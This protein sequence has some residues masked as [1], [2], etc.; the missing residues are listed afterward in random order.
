M[1]A[2]PDDIFLPVADAM[3]LHARR[4]RGGNATPA[5]C[6]PGLTRNAADFNGI[7][8]AIA[9]TGRDVYALSLRGRGRS[10]R[11]ADEITYHPLVYRDDVIAALNALNLNEVIFV[12]TSLGGIVTMLVNEIAPERVR[13]AVLN[14][15]GPTLAE[16]GLQRIA[17]YVGGDAGPAA[18]LD[19][20]ADRI[21]A[22]NAVAFPEADDEFWRA[23]A[24]RTF[25]HGSDGWS[26]DYDPGIARAFVTAPP[27]P[28]LAAP[29]ASL[30][31]T[32]TLLV[33][34][35]LSDLLTTEIVDDMR[36][37]HPNFDY[38]PVPNVGHA[39]MLD[40]PSAR[41]AI[42]NFIEKID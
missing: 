23:F 27:P 17:S 2:R 19:E 36:A 29:F 22:I 41:G 24:E 28:D 25:R 8:P 33:H 30:R 31:D 37:T 39:P 1:T 35:L 5:L 4:Y 40:E 18:T 14:D 13:A 3:R 7:A 20:A 42:T 10:D 11:A 21:K 12:G 32:P 6:L 26:L 9:A 38:C 16:P 15:I 34:G